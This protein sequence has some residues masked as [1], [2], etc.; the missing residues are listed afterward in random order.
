MTATLPI[1][2]TLS[3]LPVDQASTLIVWGHGWGHD[4]H[5]FDACA[6][7]LAPRA[8]H[9][10]IDFPGFG[11]SPK[12]PDNWT[13][14]EYA[15]AMAELLAPYRAKPNLKTILWVGHSFGGRVGIQ[16]AARHPNLVDGLFL[17]AAAGLPRHRTLMQTLR[18]RAR[19]AAFKTLK[20]IAPLIHQDIDKLREKFGSSDY[21]NAGPMRPIFVNVV[22][23]N[24]SEQA[25]RVTCPTQLVYGGDD[26]E[27]PPD[28]GKSY[29]RLIPNAEL[30][31]LPQ[32]DHYTVLNT[33]RHTMLKKLLAFMETMD[34]R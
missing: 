5:A 33:G 6:Q 15:D 34:K 12:P 29:R 2:Q 18:M 8:A 16:L 21:R 13:T 1:A 22:R 14:A 30:S 31:I 23:E 10:Q 7:A 28:I 27:A 19:V 20:H 25:R 32:Q 4:G 9:L 17:I 24:L 26:T 11:Q 3:G